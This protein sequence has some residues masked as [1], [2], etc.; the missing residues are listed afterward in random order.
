MQ[1][2][3]LLT[4]HLYTEAFQHPQA[5]EGVVDVPIGDAVLTAAEHPHLHPP[6]PGRNQAI[7]DH[8]IYKFGVL[9]PEGAF[10]AVHNPRHLAAAVG[11]APYQTH[12]EI[13]GKK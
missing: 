2:E 1:L 7:K 13:W 12:R 6:L 8:R 4:A 3:V 5:G 9:H 11:A 10:S